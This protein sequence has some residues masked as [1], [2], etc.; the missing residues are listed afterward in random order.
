[1]LM[2]QPAG[3]RHIVS[4]K[5]AHGVNDVARDCLVGKPLASCRLV[6]Q[7]FGFSHVGTERPLQVDNPAEGIK[8]RSAGGGGSPAAWWSTTRASL[9]D[10]PAPNHV[11]LAPEQR[12]QPVV[13]LMIGKALLPPRWSAE[14]ESRSA[15]MLVATFSS[16]SETDLI[17]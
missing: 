14:P 6:P 9:S 13:V 12:G 4:R 10:K 15:G 7:A 5:F 17:R 8:V 1:M 16:I 2:F 11:L 3:A